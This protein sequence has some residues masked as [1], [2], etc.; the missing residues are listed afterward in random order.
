MDFTA[1][2]SK[3]NHPAYRCWIH[4]LAGLVIFAPFGHHEAVLKAQT[5]AS[6][7]IN[8][9]MA[10][11]RATHLDPDFNNFADWIELRNP[12]Q[13]AVDLTGFRLTDDPGQPAR[14]IF[15]PGSRIPANG[16]LV[17][18]ADGKD[19]S[20]EALHANFKLNGGGEEILFG[21]AAGTL[22]DG[23]AYGDQ[24]ADV[25]Y[26]RTGNG[27][28][29]YF[30]SP[31]PGQANSDAAVPG[32]DLLPEPIFSIPGG[33]YPTPAMVVIS[34]PSAG[35]TLRYTTD[36]SIPDGKSAVYSVPLQV[37][38]TAVIRVRAYR[39][40]SLPSR[41]ATQTYLIGEETSLPLVS[42]AMNPDFLWNDAVG[43]YHDSN[44]QNRKSWKRPA[45]LTCFGSNGLPW[46]SED[47]SL[48]LFGNTAI[49]IAQRSLDIGF[50]EP[51]LARLFPDKQRDEFGSLILRSSSDDWKL[52]MF[53]DAMIQF[54]I[55]D[56][57]H[58][59]YQA[60]RPSVV[61]LNGAYW[62]IHN[63]RE[64]EDEEFIRSYHGDVAESIDLL[65]LDMRDG[66]VK[67]NA[68][69]RE[70]YDALIDFLNSRDLSTADGYEEAASLIDVENFTDWAI[71]EIFT[72]NA[73]WR[74]NTRMWRPRETGGRWQWLPFDLDRGYGNNFST[75]KINTHTLDDIADNYPVLRRLLENASFR[76]RFIRRFVQAMNGAF[77][78]G[79]VI[80]IIDSLQE[81]IRPEMGRHIERWGNVRGPDGDRGI[82]SL[83]QWE[84]NVEF[85]REFA[86][87]RRERVL[88]HLRSRFGLAADFN[89]SVEV[90]PSGSGSVLVDSSM[91][92]S[93]GFSGRYFR[94]SRI[95]LAASP[96]AGYSFAGWKGR[97][98]QET[99]LVPAG[100]EWKY[101]ARDHAADAGWQL[102]GFDD[103]SWITGKARL[104][105]GG[106]GE[107]TEIPYGTDPAN[108]WPTAYFRL[109]FNL[110]DPQSYDKYL[111]RLAR[112]DGAVVYVNGHAAVRSNMPEGDISYDTWSAEITS[113]A[114][115]TDFYEYEVDP[116]FFQTGV[117]CIAA[118]VHQ[119]NAG[120]SDLGF[121]LALAAAGSGQEEQIL[122][123]NPLYDVVLSA[124]LQLSAQFEVTASNLF[125][126]SIR[127]DT[128]IT[129]IHSPYVAK[130][131]VVVR[132]G[133]N[134][135]IGP[136]VE[137]RFE[138]G[139]GLIVH[140]GLQVLGQEQKP[141][142]FSRVD[143]D[144]GWNAL[145]FDHATDPCVL[146]HLELS[147]ATHGLDSTIFK[148][149]VS[150]ANSNLVLDG[151]SVHSVPQPFYVHGGK[152]EIRN[153]TFDGSHSGD[154]NANI[155]NASALIENT[156]FYGL[157]ELDFDFVDG[158]VIQNCRFTCLS[159]DPNRDCVDIGSS[160]GV[161]ILDNRIDNAAD[162]GI[163]IGESS[164]ATVRG[165]I[166]T[167]C[168]TGIAVKD[169]SDALIDG[170]TIWGCG[171]AVDIYEK[172][173]GAGGGKATVVN[174]ILSGSIDADTRVDALSTVTVSYS[175]SDRQLLQ[176]EGNLAGNPLFAAPGQGDFRLKAGSPCIDSGDPGG[177]SDPDGSRRDMGAIPYD[178]SGGYAGLK[179]NEWMASGNDRILD[180]YGESDD[181]IEIYNA[182][183][184]AVDAAGLF[185]TDDPAEPDKWRI[186][187]DHSERTLVQPGGFLVIWA[188]GDISQGVL[189][190][191][192]RLDA[193]GESVILSSLR[194]GTFY[195]VD[196][197]RFGS[198]ESGISEGR[199]PDGSGASVSFENP[200][201]GF[202]NY[203]GRAVD[204]VL[205]GPQTG[206]SFEVSPVSPLS[207]PFEWEPVL[208]E[209]D[210]V[211]SYTI[212][213]QLLESAI[214]IRD[215]TDANS[216]ARSFHAEDQGE[217]AWQVQA[218]LESGHTVL[219]PPFRFSV[220]QARASVGAGSVPAVFFLGR[221][222]PNPFNP[223]TTLRYG[224]PE[225][226][227]V[228]ILVLDM[229]GRRV[230]EW[231][232][233]EEAAGYHEISWDGRDEK[234]I[235]Q[236]SGVYIFRMKSGSF[237]AVQ[238]VVLVH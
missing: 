105:Y 174:S 142:V 160:K 39:D 158:G 2:I 3:R 212:R 132:P 56:Y 30:P 29:G 133:A 235:V 181:W 227:K 131:D 82:P 19:I 196:S 5:P 101:R 226:G 219:S 67:V 111:I 189:H 125:P 87:E 77:E 238:K 182:S 51:V 176:G 14:W 185:M 102:A 194:E 81:D 129:L 89:F 154:D 214:E 119:C 202:L 225:A 137:I 164:T 112:D 61:F 65:S 17:V 138:P 134:L 115:E 16:M 217:Y 168:K 50:E 13:T 135:S 35:G 117:N 79:R 190:A 90:S 192:F 12:A 20:G 96:A 186:P 233:T 207:V 73:S 88:E 124:D 116:S 95:P 136:S 84:V 221:P 103:S 152:V 24:E 66:S 34:N 120:S 32:L 59:D 172:V 184:R 53:R 64:K 44:P 100:S 210:P 236:S 60:Y 216:Y 57:L 195:S 161:Q 7:F 48:Q 71:L 75:D 76:E 200:T 85:M 130:T 165:N 121:D 40:G 178:A 126:S 191:G 118:E 72:G 156:V 173:A 78:P 109:K 11:N 92:T 179:I 223:V 159:S 15:P 197:V 93:T 104:G 47:A 203:R 37:D 10:V 150:S 228:R 157:G 183:S 28:W 23:I 166:I 128:L 237:E 229:L 4:G 49:Y 91:I 199:F 169:R 108:K 170:N 208:N 139:A 224:L 177:T 22:L 146:S 94:G 74:H 145:V 55:K 149:A 144:R 153:S 68:G 6:P 167:G 18:Y 140:G 114:A 215:T 232:K 106:D 46:F 99:I 63:F 97:G 70:A 231:V 222:F 188:D 218:G 31:T 58:L 171:V 38:E 206:S 113:N 8:E 21:D 127:S 201:P 27:N 163:S 234:G 62:G 230:R 36:G 187:D 42:I 54:L 198:Q 180:E 25:S 151:V 122:S 9:I 147:G 107:T 52:T 141:V 155:Q 205:I 98:A 83:D 41:I 211:R 33:F 175:L 220:V 80:H 123:L 209:A 43:I 69:S 204:I 45:Q 143:P 162:K 193:S 26:G 86:R 148:A 1:P 213:L 110:P